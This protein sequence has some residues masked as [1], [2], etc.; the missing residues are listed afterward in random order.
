[1]GD[2][3]AME[4]LAKQKLVAAQTE[5][6]NE[7]ISRLASK[8]LG[9]IDSRMAEVYSYLS[10][11]AS[12]AAWLAE[13]VEPDEEFSLENQMQYALTRGFF[14]GMLFQRAQR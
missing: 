7:F 10:E 12:D 6:A 5:R 4:R 14:L 3:I 8:S 13:G 2:R 1:M 11:F 9:E